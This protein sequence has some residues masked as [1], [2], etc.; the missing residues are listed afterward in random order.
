MIYYSGDTGFLKIPFCSLFGTLSGHI[1]SFFQGSLASVC[2][3][4]RRLTGY[5]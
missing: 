3:G 5:R 1:T 2:P 4:S